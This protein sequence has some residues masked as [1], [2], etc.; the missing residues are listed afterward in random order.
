[1]REGLVWGETLWP[2][3]EEAFRGLRNGRVLNFS[4]ICHKH[5]KYI[6]NV[7]SFG[8]R[9]GVKMQLTSYVALEST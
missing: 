4:L 1:M 5:I 2:L 7:I 9:S 6:I 3:Y 8:L